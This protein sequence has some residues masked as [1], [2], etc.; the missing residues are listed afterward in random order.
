MEEEVRDSKCAIEDHLGQAVDTFAYPY[1]RM[2]AR[3]QAVVSELFAAA[4]GTELAFVRQGS[5]PWCLERLDAYYLRPRLF[6]RYLNSPL[7][8]MYLAM[9]RALRAIRHSDL[10][11]DVARLLA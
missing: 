3:V 2:D 1:G 9:R 6:P 5:N 7:P 11:G 4:C 8:T 10:L